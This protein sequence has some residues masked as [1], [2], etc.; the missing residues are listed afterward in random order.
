VRVPRFKS[1]VLDVDSTLCAIE[2]IDWLAG[3]RSDTVRELVARTTD[4]A[5]RGDIAL[6]DIYGQRLQIVLPTRDEMAELAR[7]YLERIEPGA[8]EA[9]AVLREAHL[10]IVL[11]TGG[12][13][14]AILPLAASLNV[15]PA[16]VNATSVYFADDGSYSGFE[17]ES[18]LAQNG[19]K[20]RVVRGLGLEGPII[21]VGDGITDL[22][23]KTATPPAV[24]TF[25]GYAGIIDRPAVTSAADYV[26]HS[27]AELPEIVLG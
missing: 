4:G 3:R 22:E 7:A 1:L 10:R 23:L 17:T 15:G 21:A 19:G 12:L 14:E 24:D 9:L 2:G 20:V 27:F 26:I 11:V 18:P 13:R 8:R 6:S 25:V 16:D 5:M